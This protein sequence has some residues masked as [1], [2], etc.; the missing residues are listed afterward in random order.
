[1]KHSLFIDFTIWGNAA[2]GF[3]M[4]VVT[5]AQKGV[6]MTFIE[7]L[8][9]IVIAAVLWWLRPGPSPAGDPAC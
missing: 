6:P 9:L 5:P 3:V 1:M 8:P 7:A 4:I 2:H